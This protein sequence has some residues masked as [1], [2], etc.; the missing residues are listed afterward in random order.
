MKGI[1][2]FEWDQI[3]PLHLTAFLIWN[4]LK[5]LFILIEQKTWLQLHFRDTMQLFW[6]MGKQVREKLL[7]WEVDRD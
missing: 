7:L 6:P 3:A 5:S 2:K 1:S 4:Q